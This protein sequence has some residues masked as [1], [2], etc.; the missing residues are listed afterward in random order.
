MS[1]SFAA[2][3]SALR[4]DRGISQKQAAIELG[5]SQALLSHY[6]NGIR[7]CSL[8]F[9]TKIAAYYGVTADYLLGIADAGGQTGDLFAPDVIPGDDQPTIRTVLREIVSLAAAAEGGDENRRFFAD[10]FALCALKYR[11]AAE[12]PDGA[13]CRLCGVSLDRLCDNAPANQPSEQSADQQKTPPPVFSQTVADHA[14]ALLN[15]DIAE[16]LQ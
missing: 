2:N 7:E 4:R 14:M 15:R 5:V 6:E 9:V 13:L 11:A 1:V 3:L 12:Q 10:F 16:A 8:D